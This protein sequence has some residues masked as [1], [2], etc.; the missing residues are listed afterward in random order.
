MIRAGW[1]SSSRRFFMIGPL[2]QTVRFGRVARCLPADQVLEST[3]NG[4]PGI[5]LT[6][7][8]G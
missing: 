4:A 5:I 8:P 6:V 2:A 7:F 3:K 1:N